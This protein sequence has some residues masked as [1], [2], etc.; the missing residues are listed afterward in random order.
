[1]ISD[2]NVFVGCSWWPEYPSGVVYAI[3]DKYPTSLSLSL[4]SETSLLGFKVTLTGT[5]EGNGAPIGGATIF[6]SYSVTGGETWNDIAT[7]QTTADGS[8][9]AVWIPD[10]TGTYLVK[11]TWTPDPLYKEVESLRMLSVECFDDQNVFSVT[12]NSTLSALAF[13]S[14]TRELSFTVTGEADTTGFVELRVAKSLVANVADLKVYLDGAS[15]DYTATSTDG[16]W[17]LYFTYAHSTHNVTV[18]LGGPFPII[19]LIAASV[20]VAVVVS[21]VVLV[22]FKKRKH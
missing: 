1:V 19:S 15:L 4:N 7:T 12:S 16:A 17:V 5:L 18:N 14:E 6:L 10:A 9:S 8:Y 11:A 2:G 22:Y 21:A 3:A 13:N 20:A